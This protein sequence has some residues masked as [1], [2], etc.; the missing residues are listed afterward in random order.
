MKKQ[1][2]KLRLSRETVRG[3]ES[4]SLAKVAGGLSN[5]NYT[6]TLAAATC[7]Y[8]PPPPKTNI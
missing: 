1:T 5:P 8:I 3:L 2:K 6:C 4:D 7:A